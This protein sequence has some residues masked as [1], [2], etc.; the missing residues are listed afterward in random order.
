MQQNPVVHGKA[1]SVGGKVNGKLNKGSS[2]DEAT[3]VKLR[4]VQID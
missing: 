3:A 4:L 1:L 2:K